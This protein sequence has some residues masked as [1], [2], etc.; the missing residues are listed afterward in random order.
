MHTHHRS[1]QG[2]KEEVRKLKVCVCDI[3]LYFI[4]LVILVT[5]IV[6]TVDHLATNGLPEDSLPFVK[7][8]KN[9]YIQ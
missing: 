6:L 9:L 8:A 7:L 1:S 4:T 5:I 2:T 3:F